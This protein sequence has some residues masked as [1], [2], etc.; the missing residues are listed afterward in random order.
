MNDRAQFDGAIYGCAGNGPFEP[1]NWT[2]G[3][4]D[5]GTVVFGADSTAL[6]AAA[7]AAAV[8]KTIF[9]IEAMRWAVVA[10]AWPS[11]CA[12]RYD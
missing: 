2:L 1:P 10:L 7:G 3:G 6:A 12:R 8:G 4:I 9:S 11:V 5:G